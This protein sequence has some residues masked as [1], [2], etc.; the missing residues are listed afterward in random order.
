MSASFV[1]AAQV[2]R[3]CAQHDGGGRAALP[4]LLDI[5]GFCAHPEDELLHGRTHWPQRADQTAAAPKC[6]AIHW[7]GQRVDDFICCSGA[8]LAARGR[9]KSRERECRA[10]LQHCARYRTLSGAS[11]PY[12]PSSLTRSPGRPPPSRPSSVGKLVASAHEPSQRVECMG[13]WPPYGG[14]GVREEM[15]EQTKYRH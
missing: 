13:G 12:P 4:R 6:A 7:R 1:E 5:A 11:R 2:G 14:L 3:H 15:N 9:G 8:R 10:H